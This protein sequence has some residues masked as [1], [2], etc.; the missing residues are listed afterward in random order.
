MRCS[1]SPSLDPMPWT[2]QLTPRSFSQVPARHVR[3]LS[4]SSDSSCPRTGSFADL[5]QL[6][7]PCSVK[8]RIQTEISAIEEA[9]ASATTAP[10]LKRP[11]APQHL[12]HKHTT[13]R[14]MAL[15]I[16]K[17]GGAKAFYRGFGAN[18]L[19]SFSMQLCV[20]LSSSRSGGSSQ[21]VLTRCLVPPRQR[22]LLLLHARPHDVPEEVPAR[23]HDD[24]VRRDVPFLSEAG[25]AQRGD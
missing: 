20:L 10:S 24:C 21:A 3:P 1:R 16:L 23:R 12:P 6:A 25:A 15:R 22:L 11:N 2:K 17:E 9:I 13:A 8:T 4:P 14:Q 7:L 5:D 18:M 19:N